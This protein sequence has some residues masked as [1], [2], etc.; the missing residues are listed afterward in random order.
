MSILILHAHASR[1]LEKKEPKAA[2]LQPNSSNNMLESLRVRSP[3]T[4]LAIF[5]GLLGGAFILISLIMLGVLVGKD[6]N[7]ADPDFS[8]PGVLSTMKLLQGLSSLVIFLL[9]AWLY[10]VISFENRPMFHLG[11][12]R[13]VNNNMYIIAVL[14]IFAAFPFVF[15]LGELNN[16]IHLP[17]WMKGME[18][19][20]SKQLEAFLKADDI[21]DIILNVFLIALLPAV[22]EEICFRG[23]LQGIIHQ[24]LKHPWIAILVTAFLFSALHFQF[25]GFFPRMF[26]GVVLGALY[27]YSGSLWPSILAHFVNNATQVIA[28]SNA[29]EYI[30]KNPS[31]PAYAGIISAVFV[32]GLLYLY[33]NQARTKNNPE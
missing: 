29:P 23:A 2:N 6:I 1:T 7:P 11:I 32:A 17:E 24:I 9:P 16:S 15:W 8:K 3:W 27:W 31:I 19:N 26:L 12:R 5:L 33:R 13:P 18:K 4:Q 22:C 20:A 10:A 30:Q 14:C 25:Q 28:V 21:G